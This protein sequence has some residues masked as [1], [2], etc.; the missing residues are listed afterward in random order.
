[1]PDHQNDRDQP[2]VRTVMDVPRIQIIGI[3]GIPE[4]GSGDPLAD[5]ILRAARVQGTPLESGDV[6][7]VTQKVVSKAEGRVVDVTSIEP[8]AFASRI[9][10][11]SGRD[12]RLV[13]LVIRES[14][15]IVRMDVER[16]II[17]TETAHGFVCANAGIDTSNVPGD[18]LV[19]LLPE[20]PDR[21]AR[22]IRSRL[23]ADLPDS[24]PAVVISD[25]FGRAWRDG[26]VNFAIGVAGMDPIVDYRG[27]ADA[28]GYVLKVTAIA[29]ADELAS[30]AELVLAKA[31]KVPVAIV[32]GYRYP[33]GPGGAAGLLRDRSTDLFR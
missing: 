8:S 26:H 9:A 20:D 11:P 25:T 15:S 27:T 33:P 12:P 18:G 28:H 19:C 13:E 30:A 5:I 14:R 22:T 1:M 3:T 23:Q 7:V 31:D 4:I 16:G 2:F 10:G 29:V 21:S 32:R 17:I 6:L 24:P